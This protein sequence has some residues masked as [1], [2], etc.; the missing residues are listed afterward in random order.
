MNLRLAFLTLVVNCLSLFPS[1]IQKSI[2]RNTIQNKPLNFTI[3]PNS[4]WTAYPIQNETEILKRLP[5]NLELSSISVFKTSTPK[6][7]LFFNFFG[8]DSNY[9]NGYRLE[10]VTVVKERWSNK[11]RFIILDYY[12]NSISSDPIHWFKKPN[13]YQMSIS[14]SNQILSAHMDSNYLFVGEKNNHIKLLTSEFSTSCN[15]NIYYGTPKVHLPNL[16]QF[17]KN[18]LSKVILFDNF[19]VHN[20]LWGHTI[21]NNKPDF[22]FFYPHSILFDIIPEKLVDEAEINY[23]E[24]DKIQPGD[25]FFFGD[26]LI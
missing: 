8:V 16:L 19:I 14:N 10:I 12:S 25:L 2:F 26:F 21:K 17:D 18:L 9:L 23:Q 11:K 20:K 1:F 6:K 4:I 3:R 22:A 7:Y 15:K 24:E 5:K 13:A